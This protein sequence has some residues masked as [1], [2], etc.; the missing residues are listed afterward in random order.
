MRVVLLLSIAFIGFAHWWSGR[1]APMPRVEIHGAWITPVGTAPLNSA[2]ADATLRH[3][4][5]LGVTTIAI[6]PE[7]NLPI[8]DQ[9]VLEYGGSDDA[10]RAFL[11]RARALGLGVFVMPRIES[12][13]FFAPGDVKPWRGTL[14]M[15]SAADWAAF[16]DA[17]EKMIVHYAKLAREELIDG[18]T[19]ADA[20]RS[21][22]G[23]GLEYRVAVKGFPDRWRSIARAARAAFGGS[24]TYS[25]NWDDYDQITWWDAVDVIGIGAYFEILRDGRADTDT[26]GTRPPGSA[27]E[28]MRGWLPVRDALAAFSARFDRPILFTEAGYTTFADTG[29]LPWKWQ[30]DQRPLDPSQQAAC[31]RAMLQ[32]FTDLIWWRGVCFWKFVTDPGAVPPWDYSPQ[33]REAEKVL[34]ASW[35]R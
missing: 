17:Y 4:V 28:L 30:N 34:R 29:W 13:A 20:A 11:R 10:L 2:L 18:A 16:H 22:F 14:K 26:T 3:L 23:I 12:P 21:I 7:V 5:D 1:T 32:T 8:V 33:G 9:P 19:P 31:Y 35:G 24:I 15:N 6:G 27:A 25:A